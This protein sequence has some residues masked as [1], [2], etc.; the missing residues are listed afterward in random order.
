MLAGGIF[1]GIFPG[2]PRIAPWAGLAVSPL[3]KQVLPIGNCLGISLESS[4]GRRTGPLPPLTAGYA[5]PT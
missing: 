4:A 5:R 3:P 2:A 1:P